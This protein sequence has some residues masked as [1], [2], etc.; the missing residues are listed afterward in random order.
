MKTTVLILFLILISN[1]YSQKINYDNFDVNLANEALSISFLK[2]RDTITHLT[3]NPKYSYYTYAPEMNKIKSLR[4]PNKSDM[5]YNFY[6]F[7]NC[8]KLLY[9]DNSDHIDVTESFKKDKPKFIKESF[10]YEKNI[11]EK[12]I[13]TSRVNYGEVLFICENKKFDTYQELADFI[14]LSFDKSSSHS[15]IL[16]GQMHSKYLL[17]NYNIS[18]V[19]GLFSCCILYDKNRNK[20]VSTINIVTVI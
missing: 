18:T 9:S 15:T 19:T 20:F 17:D 2:F 5:L 10:K 13:N 4:I 6:S 11:S 16:R 12:V 8:N 7:S 3:S 14:I 1:F